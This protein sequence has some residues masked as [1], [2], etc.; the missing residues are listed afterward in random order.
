[1]FIIVLKPTS[2]IYSRDGV[3]NVWRRLVEAKRVQ[4]IWS[5]PQAG[6][7]V[8]R[9]PST[10]QQKPRRNWS[11]KLLKRIHNQ[12]VSMCSL[13]SSPDSVFKLILEDNWS[14]ESLEPDIG[15]LRSS[16]ESFGTAVLL[17]WA[18]ITLI[19]HIDVRVFSGRY[20]AAVLHREEALGPSVHPFLATM[21]SVQI[22]WVV[23]LVH[24]E[25][26]WWIS[27]SSVKP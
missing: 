18:G 14:G 21:V 12:C 20:I 15:Q 22:Q 25:P 8:V 5:H 19:G 16:K 4:I 9:V 27:T 11:C 2:G 17:V 1:M 3:Q 13:L 24:T 7:A 10:S 26:P 23:N 6:G